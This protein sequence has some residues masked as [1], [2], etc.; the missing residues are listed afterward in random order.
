MVFE[1][2]VARNNRGAPS[3]EVP[4]LKAQS[5]QTGKGDSAPMVFERRIGRNDSGQPSDE[6]PTLKGSVGDGRGAGDAEPMLVQ[7]PTLT[8]S[9][10]NNGGTGGHDGRDD[11][12]LALS[13]AREPTAAVRRLTP[14]EC[15]RLQGFP[16][17]HTLLPDEP[18][19]DGARYAALGDAVTVNVA[20]WIV[21]RLIRRRELGLE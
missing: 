6:V 20:Y 4:P 5:G 19:P 9:W 21:R 15:E 17:G 13:E 10:E 14:T 2:R 16:D 3:D 12:V 8:S 7:A 18:T 11:A 1:S